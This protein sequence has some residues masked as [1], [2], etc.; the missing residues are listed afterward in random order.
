MGIGIDEL[1]NIVKGDLRNEKEELQK[2]VDRLALEANK[3]LDEL[4]SSK[5]FSPAY[6]QWVE[7]GATH[8]GVKGKTYQQV[9]SEYWR[10]KNFLD[11]KTSTVEGAQS[12]LRD[13]SKN[14]GVY[15][16]TGKLTQEEARQFFRLADQ[17]KDYYEMS[18]QAA[19]ALD[20]QKIWNEVN[21]AI[22]SGMATLNDVENYG[23]SQIEQIAN[24]IERIE[25]EIK[26][27]ERNPFEALSP[28]TDLVG[29]SGFSK[30]V[31]TV[32]GAISKIGSKIGGF[33]K[34]L[35]GKK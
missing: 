3:R 24:W 11:A 8:F 4:E 28:P 34:G 6:N 16:A 19:K 13:I 20:Y 21:I 1:A 10:V 26:A 33:F 17:I 22:E 12:V 5:M 9:Q 14:T 7:N 29:Y 15:G 18:G 27:I 25:E 31:S 32:T 2:E 23:V 30:V 35:F